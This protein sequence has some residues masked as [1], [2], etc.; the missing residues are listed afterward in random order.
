MITHDMHL[1]LEYTDRALV[2]TDGKLLMNA[3]PAEVLTD[4]DVCDRAYLKRTSLY[5]LSV[6]CGLDDASE[7]AARFIEDERRRK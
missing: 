7:F 1:M 3:S 2:L 4:N 6:K 5:D